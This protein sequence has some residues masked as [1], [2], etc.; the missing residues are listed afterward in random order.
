MYIFF[1]WYLEVYDKKMMRNR[2]S[3]L[4]IPEFELH[5]LPWFRLDNFVDGIWLSKNETLSSSF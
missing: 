4:Q 3:D 2:D 1:P 5:C